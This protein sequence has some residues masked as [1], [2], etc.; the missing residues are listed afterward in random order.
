MYRKTDSLWLGH[1]LIVTITY[2]PSS[3]VNHYFGIYVISFIDRVR[4]GRFKIQTRY[5]PRQEIIA[6]TNTFYLKSRTMPEVEYKAYEGSFQSVLCTSRQSV[7][8][9]SNI[10]MLFHS[11]LGFLWC[12][13]LKQDK[14][15]ASC[16]GCGTDAWDSLESVVLCSS[17]YE[18]ITS[19]MWCCVRLLSLMFFSLNS[20]TWENLR[21]IPNGTSGTCHLG[22]QEHSSLCQQ[23]SVSR[24]S[25]SGWTTTRHWFSL[26]T[27]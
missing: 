12:M 19:V 21:H 4:V 10:D 22:L 1:H 9:L 5:R 27:R 15:Q 18:I 14:K 7:R 17:L 3:K 13:S 23:D 24:H 2:S 16:G 25:S 20:S 6:L 8:I 11:D 26:K